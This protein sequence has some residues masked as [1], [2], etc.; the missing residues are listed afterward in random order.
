MDNDVTMNNTVLDKSSKSHT[1]SELQHLPIP[2]VM[3][4]TECQYYIGSQND[5][6]IVFFL[7]TRP[8]WSKWL[9]TT[10]NYNKNFFAI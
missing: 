8:R 9:L 4:P 6:I 2:C 5:Q 10:E 7:K 3:L 1:S